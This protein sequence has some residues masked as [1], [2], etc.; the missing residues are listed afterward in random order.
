MWE[1]ELDTSFGLTT[2]IKNNQATVIALNGGSIVAQRNFPLIVQNNK[3]RFSQPSTV[4]NWLINNQF[5]A[6]SFRAEV[7]TVTVNSTEN[8]GQVTA[9]WKEQSQVKAQV[10]YSVAGLGSC[11]LGRDPSKVIEIC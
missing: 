5:Y 3:A 11:G 4:K 1:L 8:S 6:D 7:Q 10:S 2:S 9:K